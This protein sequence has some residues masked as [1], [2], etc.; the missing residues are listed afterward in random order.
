MGNNGD[1]V[2]CRGGRNG[3]HSK[4]FTARHVS[5]VLYKGGTNVSKEVG[6]VRMVL[7]KSLKLFKMEQRAGLIFSG[8]G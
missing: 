6:K 1:S 5:R 4:W 8:K 3:I 7:C 2:C